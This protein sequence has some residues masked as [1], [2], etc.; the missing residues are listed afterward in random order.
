M[1]NINYSI[2]ILSF[3]WISILGVYQTQAQNVPTSERDALIELYNATNGTGWTNQT[4]WNTAAPVSTWYGIIVEDLGG[5]GFGVK[6]INLSNN[7]L[8]GILPSAIEEFGVLEVLNLSNNEIGGTIPEEIEDLLSL[9]TLNISDNLIEELPSLSRL[10]SL[11]N[12]SIQNNYLQFGSLDSFFPTNTIS[13]F[14]YFPQKN[15]KVIPNIYNTVL[16]QNVTLRVSVTGSDNT[17]QWYKGNTTANPIIGA[18]SSTYLISSTSLSDIGIYTCRVS[19]NIVSGLILTSEDITVNRVEQN[20]LNFKAGDFVELDDYFEDEDAFEDSFTIEFWIKTGNLNKMVVMSKWDDN[21]EGLGKTFK[22]ET[23]EAGKLTFFTE[24]ESMTS[25]K[26][27]VDNKWHN[28]AIVKEDNG[29]NG[30]E[31]EGE[32][33]YYY[34]LWIDGAEQSDYIYQLSNNTESDNPLFLG[35]VNFTSGSFVGVIDE[36][37]IWDDNLS[38]S[39]RNSTI[40]NEVDVATLSSSFELLVYH[41]FNQGISE[42]SNPTETILI[43]VSGNDRDGVLNNFTLNNSVSNWVVGATISETKSTEPKIYLTGND[44]EIINGATT[45]SIDNDTDFGLV[46]NSGYGYYKITNLGINDLND[47]NVTIAGGDGQFTVDYAPNA[48]DIISS[49]DYTYLDIRF[50]PNQTGVQEATVIITSDDPLTPSYTFKIQGGG[51]PEIEVEENSSPISSGSFVDFGLTDKCD[52]VV[53]VFTLKN[54]GFSELNL[55]RN[56]VV[57]GNSYFQITKQPN[58]TLPAGGSSEFEITYTATYQGIQSAIVAIYSNDTENTPFTFEIQGEGSTASYPDYEWDLIGNENFSPSSILYSDLKVAKDKSL[59]IAFQDNA[60]GGLTSVM[61]YDGTSWQYVGNAGITPDVAINQSLVIANDGTLYVAYKKNSSNEV[62]ITK[63]DGSWSEIGTFGGTGSLE[64]TLDLENR[65]YLAFENELGRAKVIKYDKANEEWNTIGD[66]QDG[67]SDGQVGSISIAIDESFGQKRL[68]VAFQDKIDN[69]TSVMQYR[70]FDNEWTFYDES[71]IPPVEADQQ[72][73]TIDNGSIYVAFRDINAGTV[74]VIRSSEGWQNISSGL[75]SFPNVSI[76]NLLV[77]VDGVPYISFSSNNGTDMDIVVAK[78]D[79]FF[80]QNFSTGLEGNSNPASIALNTDGVV[81]VGYQDKTTDRAIVEKYVSQESN[82]KINVRGNGNDIVFGSTTPRIENSTDFEFLP[83]GASKTITYTIQNTGDFD[84]DI[85]DI[86]SSNPTDFSIGSFIT[87]VSPNDFITFDVTYDGSLVTSY[88]LATAT[89]TIQNSDCEKGNYSFRVRAI[90]DIIKPKFR[91]YE[92]TASIASGATSSYGTIPICRTGVTKVYTIRNEGNTDLQITNSTLMGSGN[93]A[94]TGLSTF[95]IPRL[96]TKNFSVTFTPSSTTAQS[97]TLFIS[98]NDTDF[99]SYDISF[100]GTGFINNQPPRL[101]NMPDFVRNADSTNCFFTNI[102]TFNTSENSYIPSGEAINNCRI[103]SYNYV[104]TG[105]TNTTVTSL[106][107]VEF[108]IGVTRIVWNAI[109]ENGVAS[110]T[111]NFLVTVQDKRKPTLIA[112]PNITRQADLYS[113]NLDASNFDLG[114]I[115]ASDNCLFRVENN[116]LDNYPIGQTTITWTATDSSGNIS[117]AEQIITVNPNLSV[118]PSDSL[119]LVDIYNQTGGDNW[120]TRWNFATP[121]S[122]WSGIE[123]ECGKVISIDL[124]TNNLTE[125]FPSSFLGL[126]NRRNSDFVVNIGNNRLG[127]D[128]IEDFVGQIASF[129]YSPQADIYSA[130]TE[131]SRQSASITFT[132]QTEGKFN[133]YQWYKDQVAING[134]TSPTLTITNALPSDA[135]IYTCTVQNSVATALILE[136]RPITLIVE[137]FINP[138]DSLALVNIFEQT[139]GNTSWKVKWDLFQP[140]ST[141][142]GITV[143]GNKVTELDLSSNNMTGTLPDVFDAELFLNLRYLSFF[144]NQ[145]E[146]Q[147]PFTLGELIEL[148]YL[149]LDKNNFEG[150]VPSSFGNLIN[151]QALWLSRNNLTALPNEIGD[152]MNLQNLYL[153]ANHFVSLPESIGNL[154]NLLVLNVSNNK[155]KNLPN[156]IINLDKLTEI[157]ANINFISSLP[158]GM[159]NLTS[160]VVFEMN[161]NDLTSLNMEL[162]ELINLKEFKVG[163]N[164]LE[165][166]DLLPFANRNFTVFDYSPQ[167]PINEEMD[168]LVSVNSSVSFT[169]TTQGNGNVYQWQRN[170]NPVSSLQN[171]IINRVQSR[172]AGVYIAFI[173]NLSLPDLTLERRSVQLNVACQAASSF[174]IQ[175]PQ[176]TVFCENQPF[177]LRLSINDNFLTTSQIRWR[178]DGIILAFANQRDYTVTQTGIYTAEIITPNGCTALSNKVEITTLAQPEVDISLVNTKVLESN[179][180]SSETVTYQWLKDGKP[181]EEGFESSY[182]PTETG[183]YSLL[184]LTESGCSS[185]SQTIIFTADD[186]TGIE[187]SKE[188]QN[189]SLFPNPNEG[190]FFID[191]GTILPNGKPVF[192]LIDAIGR[193]VNLTIKPISSLRYK[194]ETHNLAGGIYYL[195]IETKD[196]VVFRKFVMEE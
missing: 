106:Y 189:L 142:E 83:F 170:R 126:A 15:Y 77:D 158:T 20:A 45:T 88:K 184:V 85:S 27:I 159:Q 153:N 123:I 26:V 162:L 174:E 186:V 183:I 127:F 130:R 48:G 94:T 5:S 113:C 134:A 67:F 121:V 68:Y 18:T 64:L 171:F 150:N 44:R 52:E 175:Q 72:S 28:I 17:Y 114:E 33:S 196:G 51:A 102:L 154:S 144:D 34:T 80:W 169:I 57:S 193:K 43:D 97:A 177:G 122:T 2:F 60:V 143:S 19:S 63:F 172:D 23:T 69:Q 147:I 194:V 25:D 30:E 65:V 35:K 138:S 42:G 133:R 136:R 178:R 167:A 99:T 135:G 149:D 4:N 82:P 1:K 108:G 50:T 116:K 3:L 180:N 132:S 188:F 37:R 54:A 71:S 120:N 100:D 49:C 74:G 110:N 6:E 53:K 119:I 10:S 47:I 137:G 145:L 187:E 118:L 107:N 103:E 140:V 182:T 190:A 155:L 148:T 41:T 55:T 89:I 139:G 46:T 115:T 92:G 151:L 87:T 84:L 12:L 29:E 58:F 36:L 185:T 166:D 21:E 124:S 105:A 14:E 8:T 156:S 78:Y 128:S 79:S 61:K 111:D 90:S 59:Y 131:I 165:F 152:L 24:N 76:G 62:A 70:S 125:V 191:F 160:L 38:C 168:I 86:V 101:I 146:G 141:W 164:K 117:T 98:S 9:I 109:D 179:V 16:G 163:E 176:K 91:I 181:I 22:I 73:I 11:Q 157:Y 40:N 13:N 32:D 31:E 66:N 104:L 161:T 56:I 75:S 7:N 95:T 96:T 39:E 192:K 173:T 129:N 93:F 195:Q 112:P 81:Y